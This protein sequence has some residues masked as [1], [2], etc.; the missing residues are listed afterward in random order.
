MQFQII[1]KLT[2][3]ISTLSKVIPKDSNKLLETKC[4]G[5]NSHQKSGPCLST[6]SHMWEILSLQIRIFKIVIFN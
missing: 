6:K 4:F 2:V 3:L 5:A 1:P